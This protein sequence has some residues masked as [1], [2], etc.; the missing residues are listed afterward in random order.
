MR[1][2]VVVNRSWSFTQPH[3]RGPQSF[4]HDTL[5]ATEGV[6]D[7]QRIPLATVIM[8]TTP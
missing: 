8:G 6:S 2:D 1:A 5:F 7:R 3:A 4:G